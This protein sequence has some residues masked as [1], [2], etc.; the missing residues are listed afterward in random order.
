MSL[1]TASNLI[2]YSAH[3]T[4]QNFKSLVLPLP[5]SYLFQRISLKNVLSDV[6]P[7]QQGQIEVSHWLDRLSKLWAYFDGQ[8][9]NTNLTQLGQLLTKGRFRNL[10]RVYT[11]LLHYKPNPMFGLISTC[12]IRSFKRE[13]GGVKADRTLK[14]IAEYGKGK[15]FWP[16]TIFER[17]TIDAL[18][19]S[20]FPPILILYN[21]RVQPIK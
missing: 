8:R 3:K 1:D 16:H 20:N 7:S 18:W 19:F 13:G 2:P 15:V 17:W 11:I 5:R 10:T 9:Y 12:K 14:K 4:F 21:D 6:S